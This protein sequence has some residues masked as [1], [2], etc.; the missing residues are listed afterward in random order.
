MKRKGLAPRKLKGFALI[1]VIFLM[2][3][4]L[5]LGAILVKMVYNA[6]R[7]VHFRL[8]HEQ[9]FYLAEAGLEKGKANLADNPNW[10]TD[11]PHLPVDQSDWL[12]YYAVGENINLGDGSF[13]VIRERDKNR[14]YAVGY[15]GKGVVVLKLEFTNPPFKALKWEEL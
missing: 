5:T 11:L 8:Q 10:Y 7:G 3:A 2:A 4:L 6:G 12:I 15:K 9:A 13:K 14:L 1:A